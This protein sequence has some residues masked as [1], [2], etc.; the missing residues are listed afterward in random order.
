M[1]INYPLPPATADTV[2]EASTAAQIDEQYRQSRSESE[3]DDTV[4]SRSSR[5]FS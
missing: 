3:V 4:I 5:R 1:K 2:S